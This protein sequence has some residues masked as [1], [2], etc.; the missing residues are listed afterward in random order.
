MVTEDVTLEAAIEKL[1]IAWISTLSTII[2][3]YNNVQL[4][5]NYF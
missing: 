4:C 1:E 5:D 3:Y 2:I